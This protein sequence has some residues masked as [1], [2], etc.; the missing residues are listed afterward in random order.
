MRT[1][2]SIFWDFDLPNATTWFYFSFLLAVAIF[3]KFSRFFSIRNLDVVTLFLL[4]PGLLF[5]LQARQPVPEHQATTAQVAYLIGPNSQ[6]VMTAPVGNGSLATTKN[7]GANHDLS[8]NYRWIGYVWLLI[9][10]G[11]FLFRCFGDLILEK[12]PAL[13]P[14]LNSGGLVWLALA[15][16]ICLAAVAIRPPQPVSFTALATPQQMSETLADPV[17]RTTAPL[18]L[19]QTPF[20]PSFYLMRTFALLC[21]LSVVLGLILIGTHH[22]QNPASGLATATCYLLLPY[23]GYFV[24]QAHHVWPMALMV[25]AVYCYRRPA[26]SGIFMGLASGTMFFPALLLPVWM[27]FYWKRGIGRFLLSVSIAAGFCLGVTAFIL[28]LN[29]DLTAIVVDTLSLPDWQPWKIPTREGIWTNVHWAYRIPVFIVY[30]A[31]VLITAFWPQPK[32]LAHLLALSTAVL[33][34]IQFWY[35]DQGGVYVLWYLPFFLLMIFRPNLSDRRPDLVSSENGPLTRFKR[36][37]GQTISGL[38]KMKKNTDK[39][40]AHK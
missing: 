2:P 16:F 14:N 20:Q 19:A 23:T 22:F 1:T 37:G 28:W 39:V 8:T 9:G 32:N 35:A 18:Q 34:G 25:W 10:S 4:V 31:M 30:L 3:F 17:G 27:S 21:H 12:R 40:I 15:L 36:W 13:M 24:G 33:I 38:M 29:H 26:L 11:I 7:N 6:H 5:L